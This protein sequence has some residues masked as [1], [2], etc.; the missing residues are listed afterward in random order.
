MLSQT[1]EITKQATGHYLQGPSL[2]NLNL[3]NLLKKLSFI[4]N[5]PDHH[6]QTQGH[7]DEAMVNCN[8]LPKHKAE[9]TYRKLP[10]N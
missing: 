4:N 8:E 1:S 2:C 9:D 5:P 7:Q 10:S 3:L 6:T